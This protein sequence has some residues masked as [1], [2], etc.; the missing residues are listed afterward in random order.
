MPPCPKC[1]DSPEAL[2]FRLGDRTHTFHRR[3][4][5]ERERY[6]AEQAELRERDRRL[7]IEQ[8]RRDSGLVGRQ[9]EQTL[10]TFDEARQTEAVT[11]LRDFLDAGGWRVLVLASERPG[12]GKSHLAAAAVDAFAQQ[13][14]AA[15]FV[16]VPEFLLR[17]QA[18]FRDDSRESA[19]D[20]LRGFADSALLVLDDWGKERRTEWSVST[21]W[22][23][24]D[25]R[26]RRC[27][28]TLVTTNL[29]AQAFSTWVGPAT[30]SRISESVTWVTMRPTDYRL[31]AR[32]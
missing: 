16:A 6:E 2:T 19:L 23:L 26:Y 9:T 13:L 8:L 29:T 3:C 21:L 15:R 20:A 25:T 31:G 32:L 24:L 4:R 5:C 27:L 22:T 30:A 1:G 12:T 7:R 17:L 18:G 14:K 11:A 10:A 28:P